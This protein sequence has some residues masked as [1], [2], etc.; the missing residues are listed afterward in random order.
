VQR[1]QLRLAEVARL[2]VQHGERAD[3]L[4]F[5]GQRQAGV[6]AHVGRAGHGAHAGK[7]R[8]GR[9]VVDEEGDVAG[10]GPG[11]AGLVA[12]QFVQLGA[13][14][15]LE[16]DPPGIDQAE[17]RDRYP[18]HPRQQPHR[19]VEAFLARGVEQAQFAQDAQAP[20]FF[21]VG[22]NG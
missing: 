10:D 4:V 12:R 5:H 18:G 19:G 20:G 6:G 7:A 15:C 14:D 9:Q 11:A 21:V 3:A 8:V 16:P 1:R 17:R 22:R 2:H 13:V